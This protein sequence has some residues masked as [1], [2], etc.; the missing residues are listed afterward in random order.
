MN[1]TGTDTVASSRIDAL[2]GLSM[3]WILSTPPCFWAN[4]GNATRDAN[5]RAAVAANNARRR[6][7]AFIVF[8]P[9][10]FIYARRTSYELHIDCETGLRG[11]TGPWLRPAKPSA[12]R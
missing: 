2:G 5:A 4:A 8:L 11:C 9:D 7:L 6:P 1:G 12:P 10:R 3:C